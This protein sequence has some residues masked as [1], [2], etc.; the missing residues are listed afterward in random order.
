MDLFVDQD[1]DEDDAEV[2]DE[3]EDDRNLELSITKAHAESNYN[4]AGSRIEEQEDNIKLADFGHVMSVKAEGAIDGL[5]CAS[6]SLAV[7]AEGSC[8]TVAAAAKL[9][10]FFFLTGC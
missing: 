2:D 9:L 6:C 4:D 7:A 5:E 3:E 8:L 10:V 1:T